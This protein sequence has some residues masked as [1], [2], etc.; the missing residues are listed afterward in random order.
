MHNQAS[1]APNLYLPLRWQL[2][3]EWRV[4]A[5]LSAHLTSTKSLLSAKHALQAQNLEVQM[6]SERI[7]YNLLTTVSSWASDLLPK[8]EKENVTGQAEVLQVGATWCTTHVYDAW[9]FRAADVAGAGGHDW[10]G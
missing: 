3:R 6:A 9:V 5:F 10:A 2:M 7:I 4:R 1:S 8:V